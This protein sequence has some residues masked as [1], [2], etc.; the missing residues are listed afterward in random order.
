M[1]AENEKINENK[2]R[3]ITNLV[4]CRKSSGMQEIGFFDNRSKVIMPNKQQ[5]MLRNNNALFTSN[6]SVQLAKKFGDSAKLA[7]ER[8]KLGVKK[9]DFKKWKRGREAQHLI[10][11]A[12]CKKYNIPSALVNGADN[13]MMLPSGRKTTHNLRIKSLDKGKRSHIKKGWSH[14]AYNKYVENQIN[15]K[16]WKKDKVTKKQFLA[17]AHFLRQKNRPN[18]TGATKGFV[19]DI[20]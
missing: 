2:S 11:A 19:D 16:N 3:P 7:R 20:V 9:Y 10:P 17:L 15:K 4:T 8:Y 5:G 18:K 1:Y 14:P 6:R 13:G 12:I